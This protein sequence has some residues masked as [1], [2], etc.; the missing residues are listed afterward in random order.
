MTESY[1][2]FLDPSA[3]RSVS[4]MEEAA[5]APPV[6]H[7]LSTAV[8][9]GTRRHPPGYLFAL[10]MPGRSQACT[11]LG[12]PSYATLS[13]R[14]VVVSASTRQVHDGN[15]PRRPVSLTDTARTQ[16]DQAMERTRATLYSAGTARN[17]NSHVARY[18]AF[19]RTQPT[20]PWP[21]TLSKLERF[22]VWYI[23]LADNQQYPGQPH[24]PNC[25]RN[26][27]AALKAV[28]LLGDAPVESDLAAAA[29]TEDTYSWQV[30]RVQ[31]HLLKRIEQALAKAVPARDLQSPP[32][33]M[34]LLARMW[35]LNCPDLKAAPWTALRNRSWQGVMH[36]AMLRPNEATGLCLGDFE[37]L[38]SSSPSGGTTPRLDGLK[39]SVRAPKTA[40]A[41]KQSTYVTH[42]P[43]HPQQDAVAATI[44]LFRRY[45]AWEGEG[46]AM[47][48]KPS[49]RHMPYL[50]ACR[51]GFT[52][53]SDPRHT[54]G[55]VST[56]ARM[57][58]RDLT[59][60][61]RH[62]IISV[63]IGADTAARYCG[64]SYRSGGA[65]DLRDAG[66]PLDVIVM[67]GRW[68]S[69]CWKVY[70]RN[71]PDMT[72]L[73]KPLPQTSVM[74][75]LEMAKDPWQLTNRE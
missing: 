13:I 34:A 29:A 1:A 60:I 27:V 11:V 71:N 64:R 20:S 45:G 33:R 2:S 74:S 25:L 8:I 58:A 31:E 39:I 44:E 15:V 37:L 50:L 54:L 63:G 12:W 65:T 69:E 59:L 47:T 68:R 3:R 7:R 32:M 4:T 22:Y 10:L 6:S 56:I 43:G 24:K 73:V 61:T 46:L 36:S 38:W 26:I 53:A 41:G 55:K 14:L 30:T 57:S 21:V 62:D 28:I 49:M 70:V 35:E 16:L 23:L 48:I 40:Q 67:L 72:R 5:L 75:Y 9:A 19:C 18:V 51:A 42:F 66:T 17:Y 52:S